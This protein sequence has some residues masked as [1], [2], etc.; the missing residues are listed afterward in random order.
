MK[1]V[2]YTSEFLPFLREWVDDHSVNPRVL[3]ELPEIGFMVFDEGVPVNCCF[4]R[5]MENCQYALVDGLMTNPTVRP[6]IRNLANDLVAMAII[7]KA[8]KL[9][10]RELHFISVDS[11]TI[12]R[13]ARLGFEVL[14]HQSM[15]LVL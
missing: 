4:L 12:S 14:P 5:K 7:D 9:G 2:E 13:G 11:N 15:K 8:K 6:E 3:E 10:L 1:L